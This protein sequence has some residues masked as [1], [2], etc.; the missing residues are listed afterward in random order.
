[1][2]ISYKCTAY[3]TVYHTVTRCN[4]ARSRFP[5]RGRDK[6]PGRAFGVRERLVIMMFWHRESVTM[7]AS[8]CYRPSILFLFLSFLLSHPPLSISQAF[9]RVST[10]LLILSSDLYIFRYLSNNEYFSTCFG[11]LSWIKIWP[12][13]FQVPPGDTIIL[14]M[15]TRVPWKS[16]QKIP[17]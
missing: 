17:T 3:R 14:F 16:S 5:Q 6:G 10:L 2:K 15:E 11:T 4:T 1:M 13:H 12:T 7:I 9:S 8:T